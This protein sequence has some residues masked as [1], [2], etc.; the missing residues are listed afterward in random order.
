[1]KPAILIGVAVAILIFGDLL[2]NDGRIAT[3]VQREF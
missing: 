1:M 3:S 2:F